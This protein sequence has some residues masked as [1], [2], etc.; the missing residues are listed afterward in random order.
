MQPVAQFVVVAAA[1]GTFQAHSAMVSFKRKKS[2]TDGSAGTTTAAADATDATNLAPAAAAATSPSGRRKSILDNVE[3]HIPGA[4]SFTRRWRTSLH[5]STDSMPAP[6]RADALR[7]LVTFC[8]EPENKV[9][10]WHET[11]TRKV[12]LD[13]AAPGQ[14]DV[15]RRLALTAVA[16]LAVAALNRPSIWQDARA[17]IVAAG[18]DSES[19]GVRRQALWCLVNLCSSDTLP[20]MAALGDDSAIGAAWWDDAADGARAIM[21]RSA[22]PHQPHDLRMLAV[23]ALTNLADRPSHRRSIWDD[24][25]TRAALLGCADR[26]EPELLRMQAMRTVLGLANDEENKGSLRRKWAS[27][28]AEGARWREMLAAPVADTRSRVNEPAK[29]LLS[30]LDIPADELQSAIAALAKDEQASPSRASPRALWRGA[31]TAVIDAVRAADSLGEGARE[32][33]CSLDE[34]SSNLAVLRT[35]NEMG[36][37]K[38]SAVVGHRRNSFDG[39]SGRGTASSLDAAATSGVASKEQG[40]PRTAGQRKA[41]NWAGA[42]EWRSDDEAAAHSFRLE[43]SQQGRS[44]LRGANSA[45]VDR[46]PSVLARPRSERRLPW[47]RP[48]LTAA[49][50]SA[51]LLGGSRSSRKVAPEAPAQISVSSTG[52]KIVPLSLLTPEL[53]MEET[54]E[55]WSFRIRNITAY[56]RADLGGDGDL[57]ASFKTHAKSSDSVNFSLGGVED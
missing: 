42:A 55:D 18:A 3:L 28:D 13:C 4:D 44:I 40:S 45:L 54:G 32:R 14:P 25:A 43:D 41:V 49:F 11:E 7:V 20:G 34:A 22:G 23:L 2:C 12:L 17:A 33:R 16:S 35:A 38:A 48:Q 5:R 39:V 8:N 46:H 6:V 57:E 27:L 52:V 26:C 1:F 9:D 29:H 50:W 10:F 31:A 24:D 30:R 53:Y 56:L 51:K 47:A 15:V 19:E 36:A 21:R 37:A